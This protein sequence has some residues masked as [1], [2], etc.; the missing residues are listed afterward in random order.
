MYRSSAEK[1][2]FGKII[3]MGY[4]SVT[5]NRGTPRLTFFFRTGTT[6]ALQ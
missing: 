4:L 3:E 2:P 5:A 1:E 6:D